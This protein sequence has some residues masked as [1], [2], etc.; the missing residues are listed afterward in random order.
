MNVIYK[1]S[2][3]QPRS[4]LTLLE[5][6]ARQLEEIVDESSGP[7]SAEWDRLE[8]AQG[9]SL[10]ALRVVSDSMGELV[11]TFTLDELANSQHMRFRLLDIWG[12]LLQ[13]YSHKLLDEMR[14]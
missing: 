2:V 7:V 13:F 6:A 5:Q 3:K 11:T 9:H 1:D 14:R 4:A 12:D 10:Y 8:H